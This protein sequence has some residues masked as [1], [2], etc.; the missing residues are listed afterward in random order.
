[1]ISDFLKETAGTGVD[2]GGTE[3]TLGAGADAAGI[4]SRVGTGE[5]IEE[6]PMTVDVAEVFA[7]T[8]EVTQPVAVIKS[9]I[10]KMAPIPSIRDFI[11]ET[12]LRTI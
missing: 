8:F 12:R 9:S 6:V 1:M 2:V 3:I 5:V 4:V 7:F 10:K 11:E